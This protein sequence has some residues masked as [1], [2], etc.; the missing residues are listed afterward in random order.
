MSLT[1]ADI[2]VR[3]LRGHLAEYLSRVRAGESLVITSHGEPVARLVPY[4]P[5]QPAPRRFGFM[6][7][8]FSVPDDFDAPLPEYDAMFNGPIEPPKA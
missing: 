3:E 6:A 1:L 4:V 5:D 2:P 8:Q 7:G